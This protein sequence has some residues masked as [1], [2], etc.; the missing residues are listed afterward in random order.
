[1]L[2]YLHVL[3]FEYLEAIWESGLSCLGLSE[4]IDNL[5][6]W[7]SLFDIVIVEVDN[8]IPIWESL[9]SDAVAKYYF[10]L[11]TQISSLDLTV[12]ANYLILDRRL[13]GVV[14]VMVF[15]WEFHF[16]IF[17]LFVV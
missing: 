17:F 5:G 9:P 1:M 14:G 4:I 8:G 6:V 11:A 10:F 12:I 13:L 7:E 3:E 16:I 2:L 15:G